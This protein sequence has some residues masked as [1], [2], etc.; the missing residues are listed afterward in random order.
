MSDSTNHAERLLREGARTGGQEPAEIQDA[1]RVRRQ[2]LAT[3]AKEL[4]IAGKLRSFGDERGMAKSLGRLHEYHS[5][6]FRR[7]R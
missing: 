1:L 6:L 3:A 5:Y 4:G 7:R 2:Y